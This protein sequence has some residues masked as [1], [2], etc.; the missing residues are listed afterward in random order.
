MKAGIERTERITA[1][2]VSD[3]NMRASCADKERHKLREEN[4]KYNK[5]NSEMME[6]IDQLSASIFVLIISRIILLILMAYRTPVVVHDFGDFL[7]SIGEVAS[8]IWQGTIESCGE[9]WTIRQ[10]IPFKYI[11]SVIAGSLVVLS[12][13]LLQGLALGIPFAFGYV[14]VKYVHEKI[15]DALTMGEVLIS[16]IIVICGGEYLSRLNIN[17]ILLWIL[18]QI[19]YVVIRAHLTSDR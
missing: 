4:R 18:I 15:W 19:I 13:I 14:A 2:Q 1:A 12:F 10:N 5:E 17:L 16:I 8:E 3:A 11:D 9:V 7:Q 6:R